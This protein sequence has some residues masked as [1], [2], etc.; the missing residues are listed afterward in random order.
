M[1]KLKWV[2]RKATWKWLFW[3]LWY[4][5]QPQSSDFDKTMRRVI[6]TRAPWWKFKPFV[7]H[8][9]HGK[10][11]EVYF[12]PSASVVKRTALPPLD[13][14]VCRETGKIVGIIVPEHI[15]KNGRQE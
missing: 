5:P 10:F 9:E 6:R 15:L 2:F 4:L 12:E 14:H 11:W 1:K 13:V 3:T 8:S 7:I